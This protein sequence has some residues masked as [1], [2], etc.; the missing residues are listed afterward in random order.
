MS[1]AWAGAK[2]LSEIDWETWRAC[3][4]A[5]LVFVFR[6]EEILLINKKTGLGKGKINA[7]GGKVDPGEETEAC[8]IRECQEELGITVSNLE[9]CGQHRFQFVDGYSI[10]VWVYRTQSF[11]GVPYETRE[12]APL[13][14]RQDEVPYQEMWEDDRFWIPMLIRGE[15][16]QTRW[17]FDEDTMVDF[18]IESDG[19]IESWEHENIKLGAV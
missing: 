14:V 3:D 16:F 8:A 2:K 6:G 4:P 13:W 11:E 5:T 9:Y 7:P 18:K 1:K 17:I 12:A 10:H 15:R 19:N